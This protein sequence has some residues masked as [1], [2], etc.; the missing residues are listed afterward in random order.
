MKLKDSSGKESTS[1]GL[2][3]ISFWTLWALGILQALGY[4]NTTGPFV[5]LTVMMGSL[6]FG[7][8]VDFSN[9]FNKKKE[10]ETDNEE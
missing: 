8:R 7:R 6:Y 10:K 9:L 5:E 3:L 1:Q 2:L 4:I